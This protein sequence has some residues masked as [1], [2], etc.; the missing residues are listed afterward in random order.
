MQFGLLR[1]I[2]PSIVQRR[3]YVTF[4]S[5][6]KMEIE[7]RQYKELPLNKIRKETEE[8]IDEEEETQTKTEDVTKQIKEENAKNTKSKWKTRFLFSILTTLNVYLLYEFYHFDQKNQLE[9]FNQTIMNST[10]QTMKSFQQSTQQFFKDYLY[11]YLDQFRRTYFSDNSSNVSTTNANQ[12]KHQISKK[13]ESV[14]K[15]QS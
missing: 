3:K 9:S 1:R 14:V 4:T 7:K 13:I 8:F 10:S 11:P 5:I 6:Q 12:F 2:A 15:E